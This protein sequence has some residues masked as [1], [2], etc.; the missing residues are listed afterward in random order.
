MNSSQVLSGKRMRLFPLLVVLAASWSPGLLRAQ[1][2][3]TVT[4]FQE[5]AAAAADDDFRIQLQAGGNGAYGNTRGVGFNLAGSLLYRRGQNRFEAEVGYLYGVAQQPL[6][7]VNDPFGV[8]C[9]GINPAT[10]APASVRSGEFQD[11][12]ESANNLTWRLRYDHF[13]DV[14]NAFF[15]AHRGRRD[16]FAGL[17]VRLTLQAGYSR[18][19][20]RETNHRMWL[21]MGID[22]TYDNYSDTVQRQLAAGPAITIPLQSANERLVPSVRLFYGYENRINEALTY[23]TGLEVLWNV[24]NPTHFRFDWQNQIRSR[25][26]GFLELS[27]DLTMRLDGQPPGQNTPWNNNPTFINPLD[28]AMLRRAGQVTQMFDV[29]STLNLVGT[30]DVDGAPAAV[31]PEPEPEVVAP[32]CPACPACAPA[33]PTPGTDAT[34]TTPA[35]EIPA[36]PAA[37]TP[38][39]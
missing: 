33:E 7:C 37:T 25:I 31:E 21:D 3:A 22:A 26:A 14:D 6:N 8:G 30:I 12:A 20:L 27:F 18:V 2:A 11:W 9:Q 13:V 19:L 38:A 4:R 28:P 10:T 35:E 32:A 1:A 23:Q 36:A 15:V 17:D 24:V 16:L 5:A 29:I 34:T 39:T